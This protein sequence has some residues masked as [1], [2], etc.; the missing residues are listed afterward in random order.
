MLKKIK[1][2][3]NFLFHCKQFFPCLEIPNESLGVTQET[4]IENLGVAS[5]SSKL[6]IIETY[7][8]TDHLK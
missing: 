1:L 8:L 6:R 4:F 7:S 2:Y 3:L 5:I